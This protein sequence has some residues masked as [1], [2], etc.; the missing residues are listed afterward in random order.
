MDLPAWLVPELGTSS[1]LS[2]NTRRVTAPGP[3]WIFLAPS[4]EGECA[5]RPALLEQEASLTPGSAAEGPT[6]RAAV[7]EAPCPLFLP[8]SVLGGASSSPH[9]EEGQWASL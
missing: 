9:G 6:W 7:E 8:P 3:L 1:Q 2:G 5:G 4:P